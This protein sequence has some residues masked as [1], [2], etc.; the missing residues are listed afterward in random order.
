M[1]GTYII[2]MADMSGTAEAFGTVTLIAHW[3]HLNRAAKLLPLCGLEYY[4]SIEKHPDTRIG[5][6]GSP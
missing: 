4:E 2:T 1:V 6:I 3:L 5:K